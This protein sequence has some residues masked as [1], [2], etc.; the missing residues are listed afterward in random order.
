[1][2]ERRGPGRLRRRQWLAVS[3]GALAGVIAGCLGNDGGDDNSSGDRAQNRSQTDG[4]TQSQPPA[5][6]PA[7]SDIQ[8]GNSDGVGQL[9]AGDDHPIAVTVSNT[10]PVRDTFTVEVVARPLDDDGAPTVTDTQ[11][12]SLSPDEQDQVVFE[13]VTPDL[14]TGGYRVTAS[15]GDQS[16]ADIL[17]LG[18][19]D[20][21]TV[22]F[23]IRSPVAGDFTLQSGELRVVNNLD[24][25][26]MERVVATIDPVERPE[27]SI[28]V[29]LDSPHTAEL[30]N[31]NE[32]VVPPVTKQFTASDP[33]DKEIILDGHYRPNGADESSLRFASVTYLPDRVNDSRYKSEDV[34]F[35]F[36][37]Y[38]NDFNYHST[39]TYGTPTSNKSDLPGIRDPIH[40]YGAD[41]QA[42]ANKHSLLDPMHSLEVGESNFYWYAGLRDQWEPAITATDSFSL[43]HRPGRAD[44]FSF[45]QPDPA[46]REYLGIQQV[47]DREAHVFA[48]DASDESLFTS[49]RVYIDVETKYGL[50]AEMTPV[51]DDGA[52]GGSWKSVEFFGHDEDHSIDWGLLKSRSTDQTSDGTWTEPLDH[53]PW[54]VHQ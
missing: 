18:D 13:G 54:E 36:G 33:R 53:L 10:G 14:I 42:I 25:D 27:P 5:G 26:S 39:Y 11:P 48:I 4:D 29:P 43:I 45:T 7:L 32:G 24:D 51:N 30:T 34:W 31:I 6:T 37:Q 28:S 22:T 8:I 41:M 46:E 47:R 15:V 9:N 49:G 23:D 12:I 50:R 16:V 40:G 2:T 21:A 52:P 44:P 38:T 17:T 19:L 3:G 1:M 35:M 20:S